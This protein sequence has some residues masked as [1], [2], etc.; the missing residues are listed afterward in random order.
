MQ[1]L[2]ALNPVELV[3]GEIQKYVGKFLS[4]KS[5]LNVLRTS[6]Q[7]NIRSQAENLYLAQT[8]LERELKAVLMMID[9]MKSGSYNMGEVVQ[10]GSFAFNLYQH[11]K[12]VDELQR[13]AAQSG[14][15]PSLFPAGNAM[16]IMAGLG[17]LALGWYLWKA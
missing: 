17:V 4:K 12:D 13:R 7:L 9:R 10:A 11:T 16:M 3:E 2:G 8:S 1:A 14:A 6:E 5:I 15:I